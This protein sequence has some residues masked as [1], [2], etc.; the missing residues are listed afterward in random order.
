MAEDQLALVSLPAEL[1]LQILSYLDPPTL[2]QVSAT[3]QALRHHALSD[4]LW[5]THVNTDLSDPITSPYPLHNFRDLY[6]AQHPY[7]F[8]VQRRLWISDANDVGKLLLTRYNNEHGC[9]EGYTVA[10]ERGPYSP[11]RWSRNPNIFIHHFE[12]HV[13]LDM[14]KP[15]IRIAVGSTKTDDATAP[16]KRSNNGILSLRSTG[17]EKARRSILS[18]EVILD[19][20]SSSGPHGVKSSLMLARDYPA[21]LDQTHVSLWP[22]PILPAPS[23]TDNTSSDGFSATTHRPI[24]LSEV[25]QNAFRIKNWFEFP[26]RQARSNIA[27]NIAVGLDRVA[28]AAGLGFT[29]AET[30]RRGLQIHTYGTLSPEAYTPTPRKPFRGIYCG[31][32]S[33]HGCEF[34]LV[35]QPEHGT[36]DPLPQGIAWL[37]EWLDGGERA[38]HQD[39]R[40]G[41]RNRES[42]MALLIGSYL[43]GGPV[44]HFPTGHMHPDGES[45]DEEQPFQGETPELQPQQSPAERPFAS[46]SAQAAPVEDSETD[47][48][49]YSGRLVGIKLTG[50][51]NIPR[52]QITFIAPDLGDKGFIR[53]ANEEP[54]RGARVVKSA[55]HVAGRGFRN[56]KRALSLVQIAY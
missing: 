52:G 49:V 21:T 42:A 17:Q 24:R 9:I 47:P 41:Q 45:D 56:G 26:N 27:S 37:R 11:E 40:A 30:E 2:A 36:E 53:V 31:D 16:P 22:P 55:G 7:W 4:H 48:D 43:G 1:A 12:P 14:N 33:A 19:C 8:I 6:I 44:Q 34:L 5:H 46:S 3:C 20:S 32:Y 54:F 28:S 38:G 10:A 18:Q 23:R 15:V 13:R 25:S 29:G 35:L 39:S 51:Q 50:D